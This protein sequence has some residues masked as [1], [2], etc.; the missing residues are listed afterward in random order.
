MQHSRVAV[1]EP[2]RLPGPG[3]TTRVPF[4]HLGRISVVDDSG[5]L[6]E[7]LRD[8]FV[9]RLEVVAADR[10][11]VNG[12][13]DTEPDVI[14]IDLNPAHPPGLTGWDLVA[15][16]RRHRDL[17]QVP[18]VLLGALDIALDSEGH[19]LGALPDVHLLALPFELDVLE[20]LVERLLTSASLPTW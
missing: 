18:I 8:I 15:L 19:Q 13:A 10:Q 3:I 4:G 11:S 1:R 14:F 12:L 6:V 17:R 20:R 9:G 5:E 2:G 7:L 16:A